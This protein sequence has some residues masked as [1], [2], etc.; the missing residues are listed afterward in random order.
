MK[1]NKDKARKKLPKG[2]GTYK[3]QHEFQSFLN[4]HT[5][6]HNHYDLGLDF[7]K[8]DF[9]KS[10]QKTLDPKNTTTWEGAKSRFLELRDEQVEIQKGLEIKNLIEEE[11]VFALL[12]NLSHHIT[13][14]NPLEPDVIR[15]RFNCWEDTENTLTVLEEAFEVLNTI[16]K[17]END[18]ETGGFKYKYWNKLTADLWAC[19]QGGLFE[20]GIYMIEV[21]R[22]LI[23]KIQTHCKEHGEIPNNC[24]FKG[25][26]DQRTHGRFLKTL[27]MCE[28]K[29]YEAMGDTQKMIKCYKNIGELF[30]SEKYPT[31]SPIE[32]AGI[33]WFTGQTRVIEAL[34]QVYKHEP[35]SELKE[36]IIGCYIDSCKHYGYE[37]TESV[38]ERG[39]ITYML[40][41]Y[42][43]N[44]DIK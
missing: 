27:W 17:Y 23:I 1:F 11:D 44:I 19:S 32:G 7:I 16:E 43:L 14:Q 42:V 31:I 41:K 28:G 38:R 21:L 26:L 13:V 3:T 30:H 35:S 10:I 9:F 8:T 5:A 6:I 33:H 18:P 29:I 39:I 12:T 25:V 37:P 15:F 20:E 24:V 40:A 22:N 34:I 2:I 36:K 4:K